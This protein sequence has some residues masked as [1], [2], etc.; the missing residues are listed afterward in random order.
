DLVEA[1]PDEAAQH[2]Q[3]RAESAD[4]DD[5]EANPLIGDVAALPA[6]RPEPVPCVVVGDRDDEGAHGRGEV[7]DVGAA[8]E[9][10]EDSQIDG[11]PDRADDAELRQLHPVPGVSETAYHALHGRGS[12]KCPAAFHARRLPRRVAA[13]PFYLTE[14]PFSPAG[15][16]HSTSTSSTTAPEGPRAHQPTIDSRRSGSPS[17]AASTVPSRLFRTQP[18]R[19]SDSARSR[20]AARKKTPCTRPLT[21]T[22][23]R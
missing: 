14:K 2:E 21:T 16:V 1:G 19:P 18:A 5:Q 7:V 6:K 20:I 4:R 12:R 8:H 9:Q 13:L 17:R 22:W 3:V 23:A 15:C 10:G 11:I